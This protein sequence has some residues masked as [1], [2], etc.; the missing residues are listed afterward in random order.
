MTRNKFFHDLLTTI[1][2]RGRNLLSPGAA[3]IVDAADLTGLCRQL[4]STRGEASGIA[5]ARSVHAGFAGA[6]EEEKVRFFR[7]LAREFGADPA[8]V[9]EAARTFAD[10]QSSKAQALLA[11]AVEPPRHELFRRLNLAPGGTASLVEMRSQ[12]LGHLK[13]EP[14]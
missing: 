4:L 7:S 13:S 12:L 1:S 8:E 3:K 11:R 14:E 5:I 6:V 9:L 2:G 10:D